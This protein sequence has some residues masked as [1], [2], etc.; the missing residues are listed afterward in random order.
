MLETDAI[1]IISF[2][3]LGFSS[4]LLQLMIEVNT[5]A[6]AAI[7]KGLVNFNN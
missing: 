3:I 5:A 1:F 2:I 7:V 6:T 4:L